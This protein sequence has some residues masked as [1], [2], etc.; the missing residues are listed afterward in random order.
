MRRLIPSMVRSVVSEMPC[1]AIA[2][3]AVSN[4]SGYD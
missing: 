2:R 3:A 1:H 4:R